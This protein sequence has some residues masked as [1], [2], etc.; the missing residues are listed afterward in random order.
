VPG[1][2][3]GLAGL[4]L[5]FIDQGPGLWSRLWQRAAGRWSGPAQLRLTSGQS[6]IAELAR[7]GRTRSVWAAGYTARDGLIALHR[8]V[9]DQA[10]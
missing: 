2:R 8:P 4:G 10:G 9:P 6:V 5:C 3:G 7:A 1:A